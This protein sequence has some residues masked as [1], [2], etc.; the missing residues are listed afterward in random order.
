[1]H[2]LSPSIYDVLEE[3]IAKDVKQHGEIQLTHA[4]ELQRRREGYCALEIGDGRRFDF[5][6]PRDF[7]RS[8]TEYAGLEAPPSGTGMESRTA[9]SPYDV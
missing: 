9:D 7:V 6:M 1:M 2:A 8:L 3:M 4:Q 5:G